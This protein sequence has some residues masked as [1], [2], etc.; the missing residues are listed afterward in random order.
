MKLLI[1]TDASVKIG[2][3]HVIRCLTIATRMRSRGHQIY[4]AMRGLPGNLF[5]IVQQHGFEVLSM[6][7]SGP[8]N[9]NLDSQELAT[10]IEEKSFDLCLID[11]YQ[12]DRNWERII[13]L[14][15]PRIAVIDDLADRHHDCDL[16]LDQNLVMNYRSRYDHLV[17]ARSVKL[18]GPAYMLLRHE[19]IAARKTVQPRNGK[20]RR[21]LIFMGGSDPTGETMKVIRALEQSK[22]DFEHVDIVVGMSNRERQSIHELCLT[23]GFTYHCQ[24][25]YIARLLA[26]ADF[27]IGAGGISLWERLYMGLPSLTTEV[28]DNQREVTDLINRDGLAIDLGWHASVTGQIY[29]DALS[30]IAKQPGRIREMSRS[31]LFFTRG[32]SSGDEFEKLMEKIGENK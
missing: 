32:M 10:I 28:A 31:A 6:N 23:L 21:L 19:F 18:L 26:E 12:I 13:N 27:A 9:Y 17:P 5:A 11:H 4:F 8:F 22:L 29:R 24:I 30:S 20:I 15:I 25:D 2:T 16:L 1:R 3:G 7:Y 14:I